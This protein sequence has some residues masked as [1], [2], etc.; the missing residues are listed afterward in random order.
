MTRTLRLAVAGFLAATT[1]AIP[2]SAAEAGTAGT[3]TTTTTQT[4]GAVGAKRAGRFM[5]RYLR[6]ANRDEWRWVRQHST[7]RM[8]QSVPLLR[9]NGD[10]GNYRRHGRCWGYDE[11]DHRTC[12]YLLSGEPMGEIGV[13]R[14]PDGAMRAIGHVLY[15]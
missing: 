7:R 15:S 4:E 10:H 12:T 11:S 8:R 6:H 3:T 13:R 5:D 9:I 14:R 2:V 1:C